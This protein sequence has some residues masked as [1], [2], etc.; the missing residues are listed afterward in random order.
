MRTSKYE[1]L[2]SQ[3]KNLIKVFHSCVGTGE[4]VFQ[5]HHHTQCEL[6]L[7]VE[8][9]GI[10]TTDSGKINFNKGDMFMFSADE[11]HCITRID[12]AINLLNIHFE[13]RM[14]WERS[15]TAELLQFIFQS[16]K[17][18]KF[19]SSDTKLKSIIETIENEGV[20]GKEESSLVQSALEFDETPAEKIAVPRVDMVC[21]DVDES[22]DEI[23]EKIIPVSL[24][25]SIQW[26]K[27]L[28]FCICVIC[29]MK[30]CSMVNRDWM[31]AV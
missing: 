1:L 27:S 10:Y 8:E 16:S 14:I 7:F 11:T 21:V 3:G 9:K 23:L 28:A 19:D 25:M 24:Y 17:K 15:D 12:E 31:S 4:R 13:P 20:L 30:W 5:S 29:S 26:I 22:I 2:D 6:S 18:N